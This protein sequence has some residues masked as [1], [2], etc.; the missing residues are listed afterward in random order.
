MFCHMVLDKKIGAE[1]KILETIFRELLSS[2]PNNFKS[3]Y[4]LEN[5]GKLK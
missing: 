2:L 1:L 4:S 5:K 3:Y